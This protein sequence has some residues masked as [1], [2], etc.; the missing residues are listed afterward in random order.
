MRNK[1]IVQKLKLLTQ[2]MTLAQ[3]DTLLAQV[4]AKDYTQLI[5]WFEGQNNPLT[6]LEL[7]EIDHGH[8]AY[9]G[10]AVIRWLTKVWIKEQHEGFIQ[11]RYIPAFKAAINPNL[12]SY[13]VNEVYEYTISQGLS[14]ETA[15][16]IY[17]KAVRMYHEEI[18]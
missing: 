12:T 13:K 9:Q 6:Q 7:D 3:L 11:N 18:N 17:K 15:M 2:T 4:R 8:P 14:V 16:R 10:T 5:A 1:P